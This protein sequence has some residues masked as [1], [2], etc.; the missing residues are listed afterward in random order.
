[1]KFTDL[2]CL[3]IINLSTMVGEN[4]EIYWSQM[5]RYHQFIHVKINM[6]KAKKWNFNVNRTFLCCFYTLYYIFYDFMPAGT[7]TRTLN[8]MGN[9]LIIFKIRFMYSLINIIWHI[10]NIQ[11][12]YTVY[13]A[14]CHMIM[15]IG[16]RRRLE[17]G[18]ELSHGSYHMVITWEGV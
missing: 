16:P 7:T 10:I 2:K 18:K 17:H 9:C 14:M 8:L 4:F 3:N 13:Y 12:Y 11:I 5:S 6:V 1:M 15:K